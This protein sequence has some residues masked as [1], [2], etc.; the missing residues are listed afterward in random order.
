MVEVEVAHRDDVDCFR[1]EAGSSQRRHDPRTLDVSHRARLVIDPLADP[2]LDE[3]ASCRRLDQEAVE[4]LEQPVLVIDLLLDEAIPEQPW[5]RPEQCARVGSERA[6]LDERSADATAEVAR[7]VDRLV[8]RR[9]SASGAFFAGFAERPFSKSR[10]NAEAVGSDW[11]WYFDPSSGD[12]YGRS[13][14]EL[15]LKNEIWPIFIP[16]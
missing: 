3:D 11:P 10:W 6:R 4:R 12:P 13:T 9:R 1:I 5:D 16:W 14:G 7:P 2:R 15:I 8:Q